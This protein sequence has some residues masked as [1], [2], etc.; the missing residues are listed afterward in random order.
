MCRKTL[1]LGAFANFTAPVSP[2]HLRFKPLD[3][4]LVKPVGDKDHAEGGFVV[5]FAHIEDLLDVAVHV[6]HRPESSRA[7]A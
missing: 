2:R 3:L 5:A 6:T 1:V 7:S 4:F